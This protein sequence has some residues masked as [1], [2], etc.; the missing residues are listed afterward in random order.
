MAIAPTKEACRRNAIIT[1]APIPRQIAFLG[2]SSIFALSQV[3]Y[4]RTIRAVS[5]FSSL[6]PCCSSALG[7]AWPGSG[8]PSGPHQLGPQ[9]K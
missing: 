8:L 4:E 2:P 1:N 7:G 9:S 3:Q 5:P 6:A